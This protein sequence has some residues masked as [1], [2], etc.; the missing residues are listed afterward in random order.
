MVTN[1]DVIDCVNRLAHLIHDGR[2]L[3][4]ASVA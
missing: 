2:D 3:L 1:P 4:L